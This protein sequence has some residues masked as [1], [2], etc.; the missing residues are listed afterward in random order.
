MYTGSTVHWHC[1][2]VVIIVPFY[3]TVLG[4]ESFV[5]LGTIFCCVCAVLML[6]KAQRKNAQSP[7]PSEAADAEYE[8]IRPLSTALESNLSDDKEMA[9]QEN[10]S[11]QHTHV[12]AEIRDCDIITTKCNDAYQVGNSLE[13]SALAVT[14]IAEQNEGQ[15]ETSSS[16]DG[17][18]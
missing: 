14:I 13:R 8:C 15:L 1:R 3:Y 12:Y 6:K 4:G 9:L 17:T 16:L 10:A 7:P 2:Q 11:Y 18:K 5:L